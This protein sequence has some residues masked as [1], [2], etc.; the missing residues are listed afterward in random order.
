LQSI[1]Q[2]T[3]EKKKRVSDL[4]REI[5][6]KL[7]IREIDEKLLSRLAVNISGYGFV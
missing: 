6:E 4:I 1:I 5:D 3:K 2:F 7:L